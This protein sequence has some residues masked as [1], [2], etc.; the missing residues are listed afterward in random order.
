VVDGAKAGG[1]MNA[2]PNTV[3]GAEAVR[4][5]PNKLEVMYWTRQLIDAEDERRHAERRYQHVLMRLRGALG[6][7]R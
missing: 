7:E 2:E 1:G 6:S 4:E 3:E 5:E